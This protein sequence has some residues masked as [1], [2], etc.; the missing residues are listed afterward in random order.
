MVLIAVIR[1]GLKWL[2]VTNTLAYCDT[3]GSK[4]GH[5]SFIVKPLALL[6]KSKENENLQKIIFESSSVLI[7]LKH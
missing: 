4:Q 5:K 6:K 2:T 7:T 3:E 1:L